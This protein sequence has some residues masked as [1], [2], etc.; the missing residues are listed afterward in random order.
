MFGKDVDRAQFSAEG[1]EKRPNH[2]GSLAGSQKI[3]H[4][5]LRMI[6]GSTPCLGTHAEEVKAHAQKK[7]LYMN[8]HTPS[9]VKAKNNS[10]IETSPNSSAGEQINKQHFSATVR[11]ES[12]IR[13]TTWMNLG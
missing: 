4:T 10:R 2:Y 12:L 11:N 6:L 13:E 3:K 8:N 5:L 1:N 7:D 9:S